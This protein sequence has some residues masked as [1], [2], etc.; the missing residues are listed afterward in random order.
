MMQKIIMTNLMFSCLKEIFATGWSNYGPYYTEFTV[1]A[2]CYFKVNFLNSHIYNKKIKRY[3][4]VLVSKDERFAQKRAIGFPGNNIEGKP[5]EE[6]ISH[7]YINGFKLDEPYTNTKIPF[8]V[9]NDPD[10]KAD[11]PITSTK[12]NKNI[13]KEYVANEN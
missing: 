7:V 5:D 11:T 3:D 4:F 8:S 12:L 2:P 1:P 9:T 13:Q 6:N 10:G